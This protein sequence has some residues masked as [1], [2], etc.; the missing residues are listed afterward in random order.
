MELREVRYEGV[1]RINLAQGTLADCCEQI[2]EHSGF[3]NAG[4]F[5]ST[6]RLSAAQ[7]GL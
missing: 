2:N 1:Y 7:E 4:V 6:E 3:I 5:C